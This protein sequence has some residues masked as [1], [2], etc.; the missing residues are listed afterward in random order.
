MQGKCA[1]GM[2]QNRRRK[3]IFR[4]AQPGEDPPRL[5]ELIQ[6]F[7]TEETKGELLERSLGVDRGMLVLALS[8]CLYV[9]FS[10]EIAEYWG[11]GISKL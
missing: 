5:E 6:A 8:R 11:R 2:T 7:E 10:V 1:V 3:R 9:Y 4:L